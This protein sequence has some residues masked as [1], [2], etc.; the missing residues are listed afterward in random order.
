MSRGSPVNKLDLVDAI[1]LAGFIDGEGTITIHKYKN[2]CRPRVMVCNTNLEI[3]EWIKFKVGKGFICKRKWKNSNWKDGY[4]WVLDGH[5]SVKNLLSQ[6]FQFL[7][8]KR[9]NAL[10]CLGLPGRVQGRADT[11]KKENEKIIAFQNLLHK[12]I[13]SLNVRGTSGTDTWDVGRAPS[14]FSSGQ[15][16]GNIVIPKVRKSL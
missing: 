10:I 14:D 7:K 12:R 15:C 16:F 9:I 8:I 3:L 1:Y 6:I 4:T 11:F 13:A 2:V 5:D